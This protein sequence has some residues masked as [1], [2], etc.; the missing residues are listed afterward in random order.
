[1]AA[2]AEEAVEK[3]AVQAVR[4][5]YVGLGF[6]A[7]AEYVNAN[8]ATTQVIWLRYFKKQ[9]DSSVNE[10]Q[11]EPIFDYVSGE[12]E[13]ESLIE[14]GIEEHDQAN[15]NVEENGVVEANHNGKDIE[16]MS[17]DAHIEDLSEEVVFPLNIDDPGNWD[18]IG[19]NLRDMLVERC[20]KR[21]N[22][23]KQDRK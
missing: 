7:K 23:E 18:T 2:T 17:V 20:P 6:V 19:Q 3:D 8:E 4:V 22:E 21:A 11:D 1:M 12:L 5:F 9:A 14:T 15:E 13:G 10:E 16:N